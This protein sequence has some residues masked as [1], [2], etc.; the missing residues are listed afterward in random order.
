MDITHALQS[1]RPGASWRIHNEDYSRLEWLEPP[2]Y[3]GGQKKPT[4][5]EVTAEVARLQKEWEDTEYQRLR[6][7]EYPD[8]KE[9]LDGI[10][11]G[12]QDQIQAYI[13]ACLAVKTKYPKP[14]GVE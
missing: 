4:E 7:V 8:F 13:D 5:E 11:K 10:V 2:V 1:L 3:E 14:E 6:A 12:D 9:Y